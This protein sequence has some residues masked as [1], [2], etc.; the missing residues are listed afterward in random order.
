MSKRYKDE[1]NNIVIDYLLKTFN[2]K[3]ILKLGQDY[4]MIKQ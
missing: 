1:F 2:V 3:Y 4:P